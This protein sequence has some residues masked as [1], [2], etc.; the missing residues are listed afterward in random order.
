MRVVGIAASVFGLRCLEALK[1][2]DECELVGV[3]TAPQKFPISYRPSGVTNVLFADVSDFCE[4]SGIPYAV[5]TG[6]M[7]DESLLA[8]VKGWRPDIFIVAG[9]YHMLPV[10]WRNIA[11]AYGLHA[12]LLP[13]YSGGAPL[14]WAII[15]GEQ[16]TGISF[17]R[18]DAGVDSG[19]I[20]GQKVVSIEVA[21][22]IATLY[23]KIE[24]LGLELISEVV[25]RL[26]SGDAVHLVQDES[27]RSVFPQRSPEDGLID[28]KQDADRLY[29]FVR[30][31]TKPYPGAFF[32][33][34]CGGVVKVW[35]VSADRVRLD[36]IEP[37][38]FTAPDGS[39]YLVG[40]DAIGLKVEST[41]VETA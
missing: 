5:M 13:K 19:P 18:F 23:A 33:M 22:T 25:P 32:V 14:V 34:G 2:V 24:L 9:W 41:T 6:G 8:E 36:G 29:D 39:L 15:N 27:Q 16:R 17:F 38:P 26:A 37:G 21:D 20:V 12:S 1:G 11:P 28:F 4:S 3:V 30:A 7:S 35:A 10:S 40:L 31:Q